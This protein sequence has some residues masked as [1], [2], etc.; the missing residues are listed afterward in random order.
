MTVRGP[1]DFQNKVIRDLYKLSTTRTGQA[2]FDEFNKAGGKSV[3]IVPESDPHNSFCLAT[4]GGNSR[5]SYNP[6]IGLSVPNGANPAQPMDAPPT[7]VLGHELVH[8]YNNATGTA[9][10]GN[11]PGT[12]PPSEPN[13]DREEELTIGVGRFSGR[14]P[15]E[16]SLRDDLRLPK[17][18]DHTGWNQP[19]PM[20][21]IR[22][23]KC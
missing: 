7:T 17:R 14:F 16:N 20:G 9:L 6:D 4:G 15:S 2:I 13:I 23:G 11:E 18:A 22:P 3:S 19:H 1:A 21:D 10:A 12:G 8:A 5:V